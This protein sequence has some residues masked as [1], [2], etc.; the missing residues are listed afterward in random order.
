MRKE[1]F[2]FIGGGIVFFLLFIAFGGLYTI[3]TPNGPVDSAYKINRLTGRVWLVKTY[4]K[5]VGTVRVLAAREAE[6]E[7]TKQLSESDMPA[8]AME[9][10]L[11][12][13]RRR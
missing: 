6:V 5:Q 9:D 1:L 7:K 13:D 8:V 11:S 3:T 10:T 4:S 12:R 2:W